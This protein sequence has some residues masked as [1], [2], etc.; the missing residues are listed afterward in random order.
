VKIL[1]QGRPPKGYEGVWE[2]TLCGHK[3][4]LDGS[5]PKPDRSADAIPAGTD[6]DWIMGCPN[7]NEIV[8]RAH[9]KDW[10]NWIPV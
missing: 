6:S 3:Y 9:R 4:E 10:Q 8:S 7:C 5:D 2:C 1:K